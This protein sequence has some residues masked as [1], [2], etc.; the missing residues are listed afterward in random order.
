MDQEYKVER[1]ISSEELDGLLQKDIDRQFKSSRPGAFHIRL[2]Y[3]L[4]TVQLVA[5]I[6][7][8]FLLD[9]KTCSNLALEL[10][11]ESGSQVQT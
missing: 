6:C 7:L 11:C 5:I 9:R 10:W 2:L 1:W 8:G 4:I 3:S